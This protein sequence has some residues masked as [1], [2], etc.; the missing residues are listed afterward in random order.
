MQVYN[1]NRRCPKCGGVAGTRYDQGKALMRRLC[2][3]CGFEWHE[4]PL[5][6]RRPIEVARDEAERRTT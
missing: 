2:V 5:D 4:R 3:R 6:Q 1:D